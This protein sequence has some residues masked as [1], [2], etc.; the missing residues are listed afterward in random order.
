MPWTLTALFAI[1]F[2]EG[3]VQ[4]RMRAVHPVSKIYSGM[5]AS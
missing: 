2:A 4:R 5:I 3:Y 1:D